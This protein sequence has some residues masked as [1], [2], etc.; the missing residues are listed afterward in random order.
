MSGDF[1]ARVVV[2]AVRSPPPDRRYE[3]SAPSGT[4]AYR[5]SGPSYRRAVDDS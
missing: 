5:L 4:A 2:V 3:A 1:A